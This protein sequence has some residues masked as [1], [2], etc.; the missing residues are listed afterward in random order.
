MTKSRL[1]PLF[2]LLLLAAGSLV[3]G[4][5][6]L[7]LMFGVEYF[8]AGLFG[9]AAYA[10]FGP[11]AGAA[12]MLAGVLPSLWYWGHPYGMILMTLENLLVCLLVKRYRLGY[13]AAS[14]LYWAVAGIPLTLLFYGAI[15]HLPGT[16]LQF[17]VFKMGLN[18]LG[19][20]AAA[21]LAIPVFALFCK[22]FPH[23]VMARRGFHDLAPSSLAGQLSNIMV[24]IILIMAMVQVGIHSRLLIVHEEDTIAEKLVYA[25]EQM[26][27]YTDTPG[28]FPV[29]EA[30]VLLDKRMPELRFRLVDRGLKPGASMEDQYGPLPSYL[31]GAADQSQIREVTERVN[32]W[33]PTLEESGSRI[34]QR[35]DSVY[36][37]DMLWNGDPRFQ[38][39]VELPA[40]TTWS[41]IYGELAQELTTAFAILALAVLIIYPICRYMNRPI[42]QL[43]GLSG[44]LSASIGTGFRPVWPDSSLVEIQALT[45]AFKLM[46]MDL[47]RQF[48]S[49]LEATREAM[50]LCDKNGAI[51]YA[52]SQLDLF[53]GERPLGLRSMKELFGAMRRFPRDDAGQL[54]QEMDSILRHVGE[55]G[56]MQRNFT[57]HHNRRNMHLSLYIT[58]V[59]GTEEMR[60][61]NRL[62]IFRDRTEEMER[63]LLQEEMIAQVSHEFRTPLTPILGYSEILRSKELP[64]DKLKSY[65]A[66]I[67]HEAVR[68]SRLVDNFLDLQRMESGRQPYYLVPSDLRELVTRTVEEWRHDGNPHPIQ[69]KLPDEPVIALADADRMRQVL[70]NLIGN[71]VK[72]SPDGSAVHV[73]AALEGG[74]IRID[75]ADN[76]LGIPEKDKEKIFRKFYRVEHNDRKKIPGSGLGLP[77][78]KEIVEGHSGQITFISRHYGGSIFT[79]WLPAYTPPATAGAVLLIGKEDGYMESLATVLAQKG[80]RVL[81]L[82]S[83]E[84][85]LF[86][87]GCGNAHMPRIIAANLVGTG[88]LNGLEFAA[89]LLSLDCQE[90]AALVFLER[91][92]SPSSFPSATA[93]AGPNQ[94]MVQAVKPFSI[95]E[96][97]QFLQPG[98][99][100]GIASA[101]M[102]Q[103][104]WSYCFFPVQEEK[105][106]RMQLAKFGLIPEVMAEMGEMLAA[107]FA[108]KGNN[109][110]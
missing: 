58:V 13:T 36:Y 72:Y 33:S 49:I 46:S 80:Q 62:F 104:G 2:V 30:F 42:V 47:N 52:N 87:I 27:L 103:P 4:L 77:I 75:I 18:G 37:V 89:R 1:I 63:E 21:S 105:V 86:A 79:V 7:R 9:F 65:S 71:A 88:L 76:G 95:R 54:Q 100:R 45:N 40:R 108:P 82:G 31:T 99:A 24:F 35:M 74:A 22:K 90:K 43:A 110:P 109:H 48:A 78:A 67:H 96:M 92:A 20:A 14:L 91:M 73:S 84:E 16:I 15:L 55:H 32:L 106:L 12:V 61:R 5:F 8:F 101:G 28:S 38:I 83:F 11:L 93:A 25:A 98:A 50:V 56:S 66:T 81:H 85:A 94:E 26:N 59:Q 69:L 68:L 44:R 3:S 102:R 97:V 51:L 34:S 64:P 17:V 107:G 29:H 70:D 53:F 41:E 60:E 19:N 10:L 6:P 57:F 23:S 39:F